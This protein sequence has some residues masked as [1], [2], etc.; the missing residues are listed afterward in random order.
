MT[1]APEK[2][3]I[4]EVCFENLPL[5]LDDIETQGGW[6]RKVRK[7][8]TVAGLLDTWELDNPDDMSEMA[9]VLRHLRN[10]MVKRRWRPIETAPKDGIRPLYLAKFD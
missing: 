3:D 1:N 8:G 6:T 7:L 5:E 9:Q 2:G 10:A 4:Q